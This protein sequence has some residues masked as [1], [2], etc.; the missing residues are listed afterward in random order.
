M[1]PFLFCLLAFILMYI[2]FDLVNNLNEMVESRL[3]LLV[4]IPYYLNLIPFIFVQTAPMAILVAIMYSLGIFNKN[5]ELLAMRSSGISLLHILMPFIM[6]GL[7]ISMTV[8]IVN[9]KVVPVSAMASAKIKDEKIEKARLSKK[10]KRHVELELGNIAFHGKKNRIIYARRYSVYQRK[11]S[12]LI[13]F[14]QD[15]KQ[16]IISKITADEAEW[17]NDRWRGKN[18]VFF[19]M[20][21]RS[22]IVGEPEFHENAYIDIEETPVDFRQRQ[23]QTEFMSYEELKKSIGYLSFVGGLTVKK[24]EVDLN[25]KLAFPFA[26]LVVILV[27]SPFAFKTSRKS[28]VILGICMSVAMVAGYYVIMS[29]SLAFGKAGF[30]SPVLAA[31]LPNIIFGAAGMILIIKNK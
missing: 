17:N 11:I 9:D 10:V 19:S 31:W 2:A 6:I 4:L 29:V 5:N 26:N 25:Q 20:D 12:E 1:G 22:R 13:I 27:A 7:L 8:F 16:N 18:V 23:N 30:I 28:G 14:D 15:K 3:D 21:K 24:L